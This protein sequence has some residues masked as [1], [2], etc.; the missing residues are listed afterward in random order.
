[1]FDG[2]NPPYNVIL[3]DPPWRYQVFSPKGEGKSASRHYETMRLPDVKALPVVELAARDCHLFLWSTTPNLP[4]ALEV[5]EAWVFRYSSMGFT[6][7][8]L[9]PRAPADGNWSPASFHV[10]MGHT[11]RKNVEFCLLGRRGS[12]KRKSK[13]VRELIVAPRR[14]HSRKPDE[15]YDRIEAYAGGPYLDLFSRQRRP[16]WDSWGD[17]VDK[18]PEAA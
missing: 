6:W 3:A 1:M 5:I 15:T 18:F 4:Q 9:N 13:A 11:T 16:G 2:L 8:K 10:G 7:A 17:E 14:E 12:P